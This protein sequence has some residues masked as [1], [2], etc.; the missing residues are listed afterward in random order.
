LARARHVAVRGKMDLGSDLDASGARMF[1]KPRADR[2]VALGGEWDKERFN[3]RVISS[4]NRTR[5][6]QEQRWRQRRQQGRDFGREKVGAGCR[7]NSR[8]GAHRVARPLCAPARSL[9]NSR[10]S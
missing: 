4:R 1:L 7:W 5:E 10:A 8:L 3:E 6:P 9:A 2:A